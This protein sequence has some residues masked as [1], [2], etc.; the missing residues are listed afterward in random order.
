M[1]SSA[2]WY[3]AADEADEACFDTV[4]SRDPTERSMLLYE[5]IILIGALNVKTPNAQA[6]RPNS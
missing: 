6:Q 2:V 5:I 1:D 3:A 4:V